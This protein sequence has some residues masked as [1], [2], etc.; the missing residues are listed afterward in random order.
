MTNITIGKLLNLPSFHHFYSIPVFQHSDLH[1]NFLIVYNYENNIVYVDLQSESGKNCE[2]RFASHFD[3][4][5]LLIGLGAVPYES[6][7][8][9]YVLEVQKN[10][11]RRGVSL[12]Y[13]V[14]NYGNLK[15]FEDLLQKYREHNR[16]TIYDPYRYS[17]TVD[18]KKYEKDSKLNIVPRNE[19]EKIRDFHPFL[20]TNRGNVYAVPCLYKDHKRNRETKIYIM[21]WYFY[22]KQLKISW[23]PSHSRKS[24]W[25]SSI[26]FIDK[27]TDKFFF[28]GELY[29]KGTFPIF[30]EQLLIQNKQYQSRLDASFSAF[31]SIIEKQKMAAKLR[32]K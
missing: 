21:G 2:S 18:E 10:I 32:I 24:R 31:V 15:I 3:K 5:N 25:R 23:K 30:L 17:Y 29:K 13:I 19:Y 20:Q 22:E 8:T 12:S 27:R 11:N 16:T 1:E 28:Q 6:W 4:D 14:E 7:T 9:C 26:V